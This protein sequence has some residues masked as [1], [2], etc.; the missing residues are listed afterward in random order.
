M[1]QQSIKAN[2]AARFGGLV[3]THEHLL[4]LYGL[5]DVGGGRFVVSEAINKMNDLMLKDIATENKGVA[6][7]TETTK[8]ILSFIGVVR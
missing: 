5:L 1:D 8:E 7:A 6:G 4:K 3:D 2:L